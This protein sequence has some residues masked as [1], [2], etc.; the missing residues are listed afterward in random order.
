[1]CCYLIFLLFY[2][3]VMTDSV[4]RDMPIKNADVIIHYD[5]PA[6]KTTF[7]NRLFFMRD[8]FH[9]DD[10]VNYYQSILGSYFIFK[11]NKLYR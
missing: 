7:G 3:A 11:T 4:M 9:G 5:L 2:V 8:N 1:M 6:K 10:K